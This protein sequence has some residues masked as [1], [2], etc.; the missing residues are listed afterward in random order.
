MIAGARSDV[1][2]GVATYDYVTREWARKMAVGRD[3]AGSPPVRVH[4]LWTI[5]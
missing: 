3:L 4:K 5:C 2:C 1:G